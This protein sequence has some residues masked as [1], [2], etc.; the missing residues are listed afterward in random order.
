[1]VPL[2]ILARV[3]PSP[4]LVDVGR[5][6]DCILRGRGSRSL[7]LFMIYDGS[8]QQRSEPEEG[9]IAGT[10]E[11]NSV[12]LSLILTWIYNATNLVSLKR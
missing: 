7:L 4:R 10:V 1:V 5:I 6:V 2:A 9:Y 11:I 8:F 3:S 12:S